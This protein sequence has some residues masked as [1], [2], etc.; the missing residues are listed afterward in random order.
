MERCREPVE[1]A[2][3]DAKLTADDID[4][5]ILV[6]GSTR[7]PAV[8]ELV[9]R[10][11]GGKEPNMSVNPDEV[12]AIGAALQAGVL[13]GEVEDVVLLDVTPL[14]L[15][16]E[17]LGGVM[18]KVI[19]RN[20]TI[21]ARR[22][23]TFSTA[24]DNQT[25]VDIVVLQGERELAADNRQLARFRLEGIRP[26][27][28]GMPQIEVTFDID[29]NGILNVSA[30]DKDTGA[31]QAVTI[32]ESTNLDP[33][34]IERMV[35]EAEEHAERGPA[36]ARGDRRPQRARRAGLPV[37]QLLSE[38][39]DRLPVNEKARA[40]QLV[41]DA[42]QAIE[43]Q[44]GLD[45]VR[46]LIADLQQIVHS[47][48]STAAAP[49]GA[50]R[51]QRAPRRRR[52]GR[53]RGRRGGRRCRIHTRVRTTT[54]CQ[55]QVAGAHERAKAAPESGATWRAEL[56]AEME[57]RYKRALADLDN[58]RKRSAREIERRVAREPRGAAARLARSRGQR[59]AGAAD[60]AGEPGRSRGC[61]RVLEQMEAILARQGVRRI[62]AAG[63]QFDPERHEAVGVR[64][65]DE[66]PDRTVVD[67]ARSGYR[68]RRPGA[69]SRRGDRLA[70]EPELQQLMAVAFRDYYEMLGVPR[71]ASEEDIR[72]AYRKLAR[73]YHPDVNKDPD[74]EDRF[75]EI[76]EAYEV[77][78][79]P[80][81]RERYDRL[82]AELEGRPGR[83]RRVGV[84][85]R[86]MATA[87]ASATCASSS[88]RR[89]RSDFSDFFEGLFGGG[90]AR[91]AHRRLRRLRGL[92]DAR[93]DQ[94]AEIELTLEEAARGGRRKISL[95]DGRDYEVNIPP[96]VRDG[97]RI[98][99]AGEGGQAGRR[100]AGDLFLRV[101]LRPHP[102]F[103]VEGRDIYVD[104]PVAPWEA[105]L[106]ATVEVPTLDGTARVKVPPGSSTGR[107][108]RLRGEGCRARGG[109][110][111]LYAVVKIE[112]PKQPHRR[113]ARAV[114][115][116]C[117][118]LE[119]RPAGERVMA[120]P[121]PRRTRTAD[122]VRRPC[123]ARGTR[124]RS[125]CS[126]ARPACT[127]S[128]CAAWCGW[129]SSSRRAAR[130]APLFRAARLAWRARRACA[131]ISASTTPAPCW[132]ASCWR[133]S[134][135]WRSGC[136]ATS[137]RNRPA[138]G[139]DMDPN[140]LTQK[141]QE[142]LHDAQTKAL[143]Y[144]HTEVDVEHLLLALLDQPDGLD[145]A[146]AR[147]R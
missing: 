90:A 119:L 111:D 6:G 135:N 26:A 124:S 77:L 79:D 46:P 121:T 109:R 39:R 136:A 61:A 65:T 98:R 114:R 12:V 105:V 59:R 141:T 36:A 138:R 100:P 102:R 19:E 134:T 63:E 128:S 106:G 29:A 89:R 1:Q 18:T 129:A 15:G 17:T 49:A 126:R 54:G 64:A 91:P 74:A 23:E 14:S 115:A 2:L 81:K 11:T 24:E 50:D 62:G 127:P 116:A 131:A 31:E 67:V 101:R 4:E 52:R 41:A 37:E 10:L 142:A 75:K 94:E 113:G 5:V 48:P 13:K 123:A 70:R 145:P 85:R 28:R 139:E 43:E 33:G 143:R 144:G 76:S 38:L 120:T 42:R 47:L 130:T 53:R 103:R 80:E 9:R 122:P 44:A 68:A 60:G 57:D 96:G 87:A 58:Y 69:A 51:R 92:H 30:R 147:A 146:P 56:A 55:Q 93:R 110:G 34:D 35:S 22:T 97:Q 32:S 3:S 25:A 21:P 107:K 78:R 140:Q 117:A 132:R 82:G 112:V 72:S 27:P 125:R 118:G 45:R 40:E 108:L 73:E 66:V 88:G 84:R 20:T 137:R 104:L 71:D 83:L 16:L 7:M 95:G 133:A 99:L 8:Q 86:G